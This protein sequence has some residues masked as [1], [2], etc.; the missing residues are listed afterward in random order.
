M[1]QEFERTAQ[2]LHAYKLDFT[3]TAEGDYKNTTVATLY[4]LW[5]QA[6]ACA[7]EESRQQVVE[8]LS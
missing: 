7:K 2:E 5:A 8:M 3:R 1:R 4:A 6:Y